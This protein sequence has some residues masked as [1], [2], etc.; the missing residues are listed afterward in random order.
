[1][2]FGGDGEIEYIAS[3]PGTAT[4]AEHA[5]R[6]LIFS[7]TEWFPPEEIAKLGQT[8]N[9]KRSASRS[10]SPFRVLLQPFS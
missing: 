2:V 7:P 3:R 8:T 6:A 1:V 9:V 10:K 5:G 4:C